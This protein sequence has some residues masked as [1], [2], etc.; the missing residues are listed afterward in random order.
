MTA[1]NAA[2]S[3][4]DRPGTNQHSCL[5]V[6]VNFAKLNPFACL[7]RDREDDIVDRRFEPLRTL[8]ELEDIRTNKHKLCPKQAATRERES[9]RQQKKRRLQN[10]TK[11]L[12]SVR[13]ESVTHK[14]SQIMVAVDIVSSNEAVLIYAKLNYLGGIQTFLVCKLFPILPILHLSSLLLERT[15]VGDGRRKGKERKS[16]SSTQMKMI[17]ETTVQVYLSCPIMF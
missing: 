11:H 2:S 6:S 12:S 14:S 5:Q 4:I 3:H 9:S 7:K 1:R 13:S 17:H 10:K 15:F 8:F 16:K